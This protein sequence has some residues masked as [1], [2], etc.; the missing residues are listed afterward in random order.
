M[1]EKDSS[2]KAM[3]KRRKDDH[4]RLESWKAI[5]NHLNRSVRTAR[6]WEACEGLPVRRHQHSK[7]ASVYAYRAELDAWQA[8]RRDQQAV[9][10]GEVETPT[11]GQTRT[12]RVPLMAAAVA[13]AFAVGLLTGTMKPL[14]SPGSERA[15]PAP[16]AADTNTELRANDTARAVMAPVFNL[17]SSG[18]VSESIAASHAIGDRIRNFPAP[19]RNELAT[20]RALHAIGVGRAD[21]ALV[22][23]NTIGDPALKR[24]VRALV[25]L[26]DGNKQAL[27]DELN[28]L[29]STSSSRSVLLLAMAGRADEALA[30]NALLGSDEAASHRSLVVEGL[31]SMQD[32]DLAGA[33]SKLNLA[34]LV[35]DIS[36]RA[37]FFVALDSLAGVIKEQGNLDQAIA[38]LENTADKRSEAASTGD[39]IFWLMCQW[40]L[41][42][43]YEADNRMA[44][45]RAKQA[46]IRRWLA[47]AD[48]DFPMVPQSATT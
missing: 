16:V 30:T 25:H 42:K 19:V 34:S 29:P 7:G 6:R 39:G 38:I 47:M 33:H 13:A 2:N 31:A 32:G 18:Q 26:A 48:D 37:Y 24:E 36:D 20:L 44:E 21:D 46:Q 22:I 8:R 9:D 43:L 35:L 27:H 40:Q 10:T 14:W 1:S 12:N 28:E 11:E 41:A 5:A 4:V 45:A 3:P 23:T 15:E 17:W